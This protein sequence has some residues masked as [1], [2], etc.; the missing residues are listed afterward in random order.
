S[1]GTVLD[2]TVL[3]R[4]VQG[5]VQCQRTRGLSKGRDLPHLE[6]CMLFCV[7]EMNTRAEIDRLV[8]AL[9][10]VAP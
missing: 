5:T 10:E 7:T 9:E 1:L 2:R 4:T 6:D 8:A 3:D